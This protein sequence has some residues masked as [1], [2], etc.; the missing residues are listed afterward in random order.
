[1]PGPQRRV[2]AES[3]RLHLGAAERPG[4]LQDSAERHLAVLR[5]RASCS[6]PKGFPPFQT[7]CR[8]I[9]ACRTRRLTKAVRTSRKR[10]TRRDLGPL[11]EG[12]AHSRTHLFRGAVAGGVDT[13]ASISAAAR[14]EELCSDVAFAARS[15]RDPRRASPH[16][17]R[18]DAFAGALSDTSAGAGTAFG[19][20]SSVALRRVDIGCLIVANDLQAGR[21]S[22]PFK[23]PRLAADNSRRR[24]SGPRN[25]TVSRPH[26]FRE[27]GVRTRRLTRSCLPCRRDHR[28]GGLAACG[29]QTFAPRSETTVERA[30]RWIVNLSAGEGF[31]G[32]FP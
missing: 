5:R 24:F 23:L 8:C 19:A 9:C 26:S 25:R 30:P 15:D 10:S 12:K 4:C 32:S 16:G 27:E 14:S 7:V 3:S 22:L 29:C 1:V 13:N 6:A 28:D 11:P 17:C 21:T 31:F 18:G 2:V 20:A